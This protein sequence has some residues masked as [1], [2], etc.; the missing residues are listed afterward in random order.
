MN[1]ILGRSSLDDRIKEVLINNLASPDTNKL[2]KLLS[3]AGKLIIHLSQ[4]EQIT[5]DDYHLFVNS[6]H[7]SPILN[8]QPHQLMQ[9]GKLD[10]DCIFKLIHLIDGSAR[11]D[12]DDQR[13]EGSSFIEIPS[14]VLNEIMKNRQND[15]SA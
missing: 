15:S 4:Q 11:S 8:G 2:S 1:P 3:S 14:I 7:R 9:L 12:N 13:V 6:Y 10:S 5:A